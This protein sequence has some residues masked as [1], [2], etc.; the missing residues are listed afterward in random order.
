MIESVWVDGV[1]DQLDRM[2]DEEVE[3]LVKAAPL[4]RKL[5]SMP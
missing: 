2:T 5:A 1:R 3:L 4:F